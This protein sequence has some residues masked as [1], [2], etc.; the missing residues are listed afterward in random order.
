MFFVS[1]S[2]VER[3]LNAIHKFIFIYQFIVEINMNLLQKKHY[4]KAYVI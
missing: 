2:A 1:E 3:T 4:N